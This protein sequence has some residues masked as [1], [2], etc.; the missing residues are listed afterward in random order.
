MI[1]Q[2]RHIQCFKLGL[3]MGFFFLL[4]PAV[5]YILDFYITVDSNCQKMSLILDTLNRYLQI[6]H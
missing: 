4:T 2:I 6:D 1:H 3:S 5:E